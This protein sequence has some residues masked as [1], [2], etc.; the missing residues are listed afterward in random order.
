MNNGKYVFSQL[1]E[2]LPQRFF[3]R[4]TDKEKEKQN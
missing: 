3:D 1:V 2:F 4:I